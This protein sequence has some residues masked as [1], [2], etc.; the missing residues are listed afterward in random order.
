MVLKVVWSEIIF[1][2]YCSL[3]VEKRN[4][5]LLMAIE[6]AVGWWVKTTWSIASLSVRQAKIIAPRGSTL[7]INSYSIIIPPDRF[8]DLLST[9]P[10]IPIRGYA[11][12]FGWYL[13]SATGVEDQ[14]RLLLLLSISDKCRW[15]ETWRKSR[16]CTRWRN[17][18]PCLGNIESRWQKAL[19]TS[20]SSL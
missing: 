18:S 11:H 7:K 1:S 16:W 4:C 19:G 13:C 8:N 17:K 3:C 12:Y 14:P 2:T 10:H 20:I 5:A 9:G 15:L 6:F